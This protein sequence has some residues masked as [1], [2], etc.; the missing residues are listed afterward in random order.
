MVFSAVRTLGDSKTGVSR[1]KVVKHVSEQSSVRAHIDRKV[2]LALRRLLSSGKIEKV[3]ANGSFFKVSRPA[4]MKVLFKVS[5][6][7]KIKVIGY[8]DRRCDEFN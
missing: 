2:I 7:A 8:G 4:K 3:G 1:E 5:H 6:P